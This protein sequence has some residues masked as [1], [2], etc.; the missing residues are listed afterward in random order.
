MNIHYKQKP[1]LFV[2]KSSNESS[3]YDDIIYKKQQID[4]PAQPVEE[5]TSEPPYTTFKP[6]TATSR[7]RVQQNRTS[8]YVKPE[9]TQD[10]KVYLNNGFQEIPSKFKLNVVLLICSFKILCYT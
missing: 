4:I 8:V 6:Y 5:S 10:S 3:R 2:E 9:M 7:Y 1:Q